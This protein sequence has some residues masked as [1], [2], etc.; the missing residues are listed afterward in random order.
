MSLRLGEERLLV[1]ALLTC[2]GAAAVPLALAGPGFVPAAAHA[3]PEWLLGPYGN[4]LNPET[5][6]R[7]GYGNHT[8]TE[9]TAFT[10][11]S[12]DLKLTSR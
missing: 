9:P 1:A 12:N 3:K 10:M 11:S 4:G 5:W 8:G 7:T 6:S 2:F